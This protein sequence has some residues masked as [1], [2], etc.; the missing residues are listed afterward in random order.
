MTN[1]YV[2][3]VMNM[4]YEIKNMKNRGF[5]IVETLV[6]ITV[7]MIS[8]AGPLVVASKGLAAALYARDQVI[9][10]YLAQESME[11]IK[12]TRD[13][14][15]AADRDWL[16]GIIDSPNCTSS[17]NPCDASAISLT[18][19]P[20]TP[21]LCSVG[22]CP[23]YFDIRTGYVTSSSGNA[24]TIFKR[25][26]YLIKPNSADACITT[27]VECQV[28]VYV[29]WNEGTVPYSVELKSELVNN[30]R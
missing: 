10:S 23:I 5:T 24:P 8:V 29:I 11:V 7:L 25:Y 26:Y 3:K 19:P 22:G 6:A 14:N 16:T 15:L 17:T 9:A 2:K 28:N 18:S 20:T 13:N 30:M 4:K 12:N 1:M 27:G 21:T